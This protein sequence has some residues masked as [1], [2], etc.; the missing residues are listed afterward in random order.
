[1]LKII[2]KNTVPSE[3]QLGKCKP[4]FFHGCANGTRVLFVGNSITKHAPKEEIG[5]FGDWGMAASEAE[6]DYAHIIA[7]IHI[8]RCGTFKPKHYQLYI[9]REIQQL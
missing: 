5:W 2:D 7:R 1:M 9:L 4:V 6:N 8:R 3:N